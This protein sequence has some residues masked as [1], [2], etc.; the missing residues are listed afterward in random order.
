MKIKTIKNMEEIFIFKSKAY[1]AN[2]EIAQA[3]YL[4]IRD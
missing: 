4:K 1:L 3:K 2:E